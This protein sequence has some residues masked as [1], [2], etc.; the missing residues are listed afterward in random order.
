MRRK[1]LAIAV[2]SM[3]ATAGWAQFERGTKYVGASV[4]GLSLSY[5]KASDFSFGLD[6]T[7]GYYFADSWMVKGNL[8]YAHKKSY[9]GFNLGGAVRYNFLQNGVYLE[10]G[11][12][13]Q[14]ENFGK[15]TI[16]V[17]VVVGDAIVGYEKVQ[18]KLHENNLRIPVNI[19]YTFYLNQHIAIE[20]AVYTKLSLNDFND[21]T[22]FGLKIGLGYYF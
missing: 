20:P 18:K 1:F 17:P 21:G 9:D 15:T 13:Y 2:F 8:G 6:A 14:F 3:I 22:E 11:L 16:D 4:S 5:S 12:E 7:G 10:A 19:G